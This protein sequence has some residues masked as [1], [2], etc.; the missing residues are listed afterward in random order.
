MIFKLIFGILP[1]TFGTI[2]NN[3]TSAMLNSVYFRLGVN[4]IAAFFLELAKA[5]TGTLKFESRQY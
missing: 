3:C 2:L 1:T 5:K 4:E